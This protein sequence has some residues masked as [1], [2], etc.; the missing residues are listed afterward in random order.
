MKNKIEIQILSPA[1]REQLLQLRDEIRKIEGLEAFDLQVP[2]APL[3]QGKMDGGLSL[4][5]LEAVISGIAHF[6]AEKS[7][8]YYQGRIAALFSR[9]LGNSKNEAVPEVEAMSGLL[10]AESDKW[11][12]AI[13]QS[14]NGATSVSCYDETGAVSIFSN[15]EYS[16]DPENTYA[17]LI[18]VSDYDDSA[19]FSRIPPVAGNLDE[20]YS[21]FSDKRLVGLPFANITRLYNENCISIKDELRRVSRTKDIKTLI[22]YYSG[23]GQNTGN[24][25]LSLIAKDT[26]N[27]DEELHNDIPYSYIEKVM[28]LSP[29]D[30][31][32]VFIDACH[33]G[34]AAQGSNSNVF[35]FEPVLGTFTLAS[36]SAEE[37]SYFKRNAATTYFTTYLSAAFKEGI[38]NSNTMLSLTD[39]YTYTSEKLL[40][41][42][43]PAP[44]SKAQLKNIQAGNFYISN[45][46]AFSLEARLNTPKQLYQQGRYAEARREY[47]LLEKEYP[48]NQQLKNEHVEFER[49]AEFNKLVKDGDLLFFRDKDFAAAQSK[50][51]EALTLKY[52]ESVRDKIADCTLSLQQ[53][54]QLVKKEPLKTNGE[55]VKTESEK[56]LLRDKHIGPVKK[57]TTLLVRAGTIAVA[58]L[59]FIFI[60]RYHGEKTLVDNNGNT[61][62]YKGDMKDGKPEGEGRAKYKNGNVFE[63]EWTNG[64]YDG[65]GTFTWASNDTYTGYFKNGYLNGKGTMKY[66][67]EEVYDGYWAYG[68]FQGRGTYK[69]KNGNTYEGYWL[70]NK[71]NGD[72]KFTWQN[73]D[74]YQ[75]NFK[76]GYRDGY[77]TTVTLSSD[78]ANCAGCRKY[79]GFWRN[80]FKEGAGSWFDI[81][82]KLIYQGSFVNDQPVPPYPNR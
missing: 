20:M 27:I 5:V 41:N 56:T 67:N 70:N 34:L 72:G 45:N 8:E 13:S 65:S 74:T 81:N 10:P 1:K 80:G 75:G 37:A 22:I 3:V 50:Y 25:Q 11:K 15:R 30:Q 42:R 69:Y 62:S 38:A 36:T 55:R 71:Q 32:I 4:V 57:K 51:R 79:S 48:D 61:Y 12:V 21:I 31:K 73:G 64:L 60:M 52:D 82:G 16:I 43:L 78:V 47:I 66:Q 33:S 58:L 7:A 49:N 28:N 18:G 9:I 26:R 68:V 23:H 17:L 77:G 40:N 6:T 46:P 14:R 44:V 53:L 54:P 19:N 35:E 29:A 2:P 39:L 59:I 63:G 24:N 76:D